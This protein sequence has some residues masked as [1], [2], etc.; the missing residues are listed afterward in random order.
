[1]VQLSKYRLVYATA[2]LELSEA[3]MGNEYPDADPAQA[4]L[5]LGKELGAA[6][7]QLKSVIKAGEKAGFDE[8][9]EYEALV[10]CLQK[11]V[12]MEDKARADAACQ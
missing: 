5:R 8:S 6:R 4:A 2:T 10:S 1:M 7:L 11:V 3:Y 9:K 12:E